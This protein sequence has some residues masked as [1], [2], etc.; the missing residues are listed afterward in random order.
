MKFLPLAKDGVSVHAGFWKRSKAMIVDALICIPCWFILDWLKR[1]DL[2]L[3]STITITSTILFQMYFVYF[4][5][6]FGGTPGKLATGLSVTRLD[7]ARTELH[8]RR[9][10]NF[11]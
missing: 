1:F 11:Y 9:A 5:A 2:A 10:Y 4:N 7:G 6:K 3:A 8:Y